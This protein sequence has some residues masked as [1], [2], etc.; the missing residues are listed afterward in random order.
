MKKYQNWLFSS[1]KWGADPLVVVF[2]PANVNVGHPG[3]VI[4]DEMSRS[5]GSRVKFE[6]PY[7]KIHQCSF[8]TPDLQLSPVLSGFWF[9]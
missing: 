7:P 2:D 1:G 6:W 3:K 9:R 8:F 5:E 4:D